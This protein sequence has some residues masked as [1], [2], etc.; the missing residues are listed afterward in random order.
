MEEMMSRKFQVSGF[1]ILICLFWGNT[2]VIGQTVKSERESEEG[3]T[4]VSRHAIVLDRPMGGPTSKMASGPLLGN[5]DVGVMQSGPADRLI[6]Y[7]GK[8]DFWALCRQ[9]PIAVGQLRLLIPEL[10]DAKFQTVS[11]M[12][13]AEIRGEY[14]KADCKLVSRAWVDAN[15]NL[16]F[17]EL[18]NKGPKPLS[19]EVQNI[20][21]SSGGEGSLPATVP[22]A[23]PPKIGC[24]QLGGGRW[25][26]K[27]EMAGVH[28]LDRALS[29]TEAGA[30]VQ[31]AR[32][33]PIAFDGETAKSATAPSVS[34]ALTVSAWIKAAQLA[35]DANYIVST[36]EWNKG[37]SLGL[38]NGKPRFA[39]GGFML[40]CDES[41]PLNQWVHLVGIFDG[42]QIALLVNGKVRKS[43]GG[44]APAEADFLYDPDA[45][46][47]EGR[48]VGLATRVVGHSASRV[49]TLAPGKSAVIVTAVLSDLDTPGK[50][51][52]AEACS[53]ANGLTLEQVAACS[54]AHR[55]WWNNYWSRS[56]IEIPDK[57]I[58]QCWY[59][60]WYIMGS[61][62][63]P[64]KVAPGL[65]GNWLTVD[66]PAWHGDWHLN[67]NF[68]AP[69]YGLYS[70]NHADITLPFYVGMNE[71][72]P[73]GK[74]IAQAKG[75]K[76]IHL[77]VSIGPW[78]MCPEGD[79]SDWGQRSNSAYAALLYIWYWQYTQDTE[80]LKA[81]G[82]PYLREVEAF[83]TDYL[84]LEEGRYMIYNDAIHEGHHPQDVNPILTL[85]MLR[86]IYGNLIPISNAL[87][88]DVDKH[89][90]WQD[91]CNRL[92]PFPTQ[93]RNGKT[94][95]RYT[96]KG[97]PWWDG[98][99]LGIQHIFPGGAIG[100]DSDPQLLEISRN[101]IDAMGRWRD[102]NGSSSWY[103]AC[104]RVGYDPDK[105]LLELRG[106]YDRHALPNK[107]LNFG[108]GGIENVSPSLAV[109]E[110]LLQSHDGVIRLFPCWP[111]NQNARFGTLRAVG[112]FLV[113]AE[114]KDGKIYGVKIISERGK[115]CSIVNPW[116]GKKIN[117]TRHGKRQESETLKGDRLT[118]K[119]AARE[120]LELQAD[121]I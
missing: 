37:Y 60:S 100:L 107:V 22:A 104:A 1:L 98:N 44:N 97:T 68:Q 59:A 120:V 57:T 78:G 7:I 56:F 20:K 87:G 76:G 36:G 15:R 62:S 113:S 66:N 45:P 109:T 26:F 13:L 116:P 50:S 89:A 27:G 69:F 84:K 106:M 83:W 24:E 47:P 29:V 65:W 54:A 88:V 58:E 101:M 51:P 40:Q 103:T 95:F 105:I 46:R 2:A 74:R 75:W 52:L 4:I 21:G 77:P 25:F 12:Q 28:I 91:I 14:S 114:I 6:F 80:W 31:A 10:R 82:Y 16:L 63:R 42:K 30:L 118:L 35:S 72:I 64:G 67:Y 94:V 81:I 11:D 53:L 43:V 49:L 110:M 96:E 92:S 19:V 70:A 79:N 86:T 93:E 9:A 48:R 102:S 8:N 38:S 17:V 18:A 41:V 73:R 61:C 23:R 112:A 39:I 32:G 85:G 111:K 119:T 3:A 55:Q 71:S 99:T 117:V 33:E 108:G 115:D 90:K 121:T 34:Q 5:G